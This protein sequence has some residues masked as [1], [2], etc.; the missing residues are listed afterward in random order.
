MRPVPW[1]YRWLGAPATARAPWQRLRMDELTARAAAA[2]IAS[3]TGLLAWGTPVREGPDGAVWAVVLLPDG[4]AG[5]PLFLRTLGDC[6]P[7]F[8]GVRVS[9]PVRATRTAD[10][11][12]AQVRS[13][14]GAVAP[15]PLPTATDHATAD[16]RE[17]DD[18]DAAPAAAD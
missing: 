1:R 4:D 16:E 6:A 17:T 13:V 5:E 3:D 18:A 12:G 15:T 10:A 14:L 11:V 2:L 7:W 9:P 8:R